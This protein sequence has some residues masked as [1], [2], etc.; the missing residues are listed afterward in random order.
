[1]ANTSSPLIPK[2]SN[3]FKTLVFEVKESGTDVVSVATSND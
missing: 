2:T 3:M 1:M